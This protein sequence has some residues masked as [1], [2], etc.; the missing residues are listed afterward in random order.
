[1]ASF[2]KK[3]LQEKIKVI[4]NEYFE[5]NDRLNILSRKK[6]IFIRLLIIIP[7]ILVISGIYLV[8]L[9]KNLFSTLGFI[10]F[11]FSLILLGVFIYS[12]MLQSRHK[13]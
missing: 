7:S 9:P 11:C 1:M 2:E 12:L 3:N 5:G 10:F 6:K 4:K 13:D 8:N